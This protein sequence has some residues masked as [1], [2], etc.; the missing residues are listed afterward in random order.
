MRSY[1][2]SSSSSICITVTQVRLLFANY[3]L[4]SYLVTYL[5]GEKRRE[6][7]AFERPVQA[8]ILYRM[9]Q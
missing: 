6:V 9:S 7:L 5:H 8:L 1:S 4:L 3:R 2:S